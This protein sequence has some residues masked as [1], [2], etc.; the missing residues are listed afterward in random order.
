[1]LVFFLLFSTII[2]DM[3]LKLILLLMTIQTIAFAQTDISLT[4]QLQKTVGGFNGEVGIYVHNLKT[5]QTAEINAD[6]V[7][8]TASMIKVSI[9]CG[10]MDKIQKGEIDYH[11]KLVFTEPLRYDTGDIL[12]SVRDKDTIELSKVAMLMI[13]MSDNTAS[14]WLQDMVTGEYINNWLEQ[15]GFEHMRVNSRVKGREEIR[16]KYGWGM[17]TPREM[18]KLFTMIGTGIAVSPEA[19][20][21]MYRN[22]GHI[23]WDDNALSQIPP[24]V[25]TASKQGFV[26]QSR[27]ETVFVNAPHGDYVFSIITNHQKDKSYKH[28]NEGFVLIRNVSA[29]LWHYFEPGSKWQQRARDEKF[30][31]TDSE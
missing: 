24:Y 5:G 8:P 22:L 29:L 25:Q 6:T 20:E 19:S 28:D 1:M 9:L 14:L 27:S 31:N 15:N 23:Y 2:I 21:R 11:Q 18:C 3:K 26:D 13:T 7:F 16:A 10:L 4:R 12:G 30:M 17:T